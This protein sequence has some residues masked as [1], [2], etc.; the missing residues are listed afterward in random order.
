MK[1]KFDLKGPLRAWNLLLSVFSLVGFLRTLPHLAYYVLSDKDGL[2]HGFYASL[3]RP[4]ETSF[5]QGANGLWTMLFIF[6]KVPE[7]VDTA[8]VVLR[9]QKRVALDS[10]PPPPPRPAPPRPPAPCSNPAPSRGTLSLPSP[11][12]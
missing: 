6:S 8:F 4:A 2:A 7:L 9:G 5:G 11:R 12:P 1:L 3:C 10:S